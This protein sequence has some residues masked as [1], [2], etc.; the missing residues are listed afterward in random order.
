MLML[1]TQAASTTSIHPHGRLI[2]HNFCIPIWP[3]KD[4]VNN[5]DKARVVWGFILFHPLSLIL[6]E[7]QIRNFLYL[8]ITSWSSS[9]YNHSCS[10]YPFNYIITP[11]IS[12]NSCILRIVPRSLLFEYIV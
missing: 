4:Q 2:Y 8:H 1:H 3:Q 11:I 9:L 6:K 12:R 7:C 5:I 10:H